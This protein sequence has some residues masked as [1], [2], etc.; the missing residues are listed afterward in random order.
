MLYPALMIFVS[1]Y[2]WINQQ[3]EA[4]AW[5]GLADH[6]ALRAAVIILVTITMFKPSG[7]TRLK[8]FKTISMGRW[9]HQGP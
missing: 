9:A 2:L 8:I 7:I 4:S 3:F 1:Q 6:A 5:A